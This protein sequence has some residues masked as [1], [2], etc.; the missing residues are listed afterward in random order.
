MPGEQ[1]RVLSGDTFVFLHAHPDDEAIFTGGTIALLATGGHRV[2]VVFATSGELGLGAGPDLAETRRSEASEACALLGVDRVVFLDHHDSGLDASGRD[3][4]SAAFAAV[5]VAEAAGQLADVV[6]QEGATALVTYDPFGVYGHPDHVHAHIVGAEAAALAGL[7][8]WY[9]V[10]VDREY[11]HFVDTH[12][13]AKAGSSVVGPPGARGIGAAT[14]EISTA[15][16]VRPALAAKLEAIAAHRSQ[17]PEDP[18][19]GSG[20]RF[21]DVYGYEWFIRNGGPTELDAL[22]SRGQVRARRSP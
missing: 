17:V 3:R 22:A 20:S 2:V 15:I 13:A 19:F 9:E 11:L 7:A 8:T 14:V 6:L 12:V 4:P 18:T 10:T 5:S 1:Q 16:D 21:A